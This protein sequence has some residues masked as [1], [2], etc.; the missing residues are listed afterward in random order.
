MTNALAATTNPA[1]YILLQPGDGK[2]TRS[3]VGMFESW[4]T[5]SGSPLYSPD[6]AAYRDRLLSTKSPTSTA[7]H[8][9][10]IR[11]AYRRA[12]RANDLRD[13]LFTDAGIALQ[14]IGAEDNPANR[15][16]FVDERITRLKNVIDPKAAPV[17]IVKSQDKPDAAQVR[18]TRAQAEALLNAP[19]VVPLKSLRDTAAIALLLCTGIREAELCALEVVDLRQKLG[20]E[21]ALHVCE[22]KGSKERLIPYGDLSW[23]LAIVDRWLKAARIGDGPVFRS[24]WKNGRSI[25]GRLS[26]RAVENIVAAYPVMI[27]GEPI[28][29]HPH[30]LRRTYARRLYEAGVDLLAI[31]QNLGHVDTKTTRLYIGPLDAAQRRAPGVYSFDLAKLN[32]V[33]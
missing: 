21:L 4:L 20:G 6:L 25:R 33:T 19:G 28:A 30:D 17:T 29:V 27:K 23:V 5:S 7:A 2:D 18:L 15:K 32:K 9:S 14:H 1:R 10:T 3:R 12:M 24:F 26:V 13:R 22:G 31:S 11:A 16:A 8:L